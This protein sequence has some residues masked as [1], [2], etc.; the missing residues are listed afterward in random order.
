MTKVLST[1]LDSVKLAEAAK[2]VAA[3]G[4][5]AFRT[6]TFYGL[7]ADPFNAAAVQKMRELKGREE[8]KPILLLISDRDQVDRFISR[9]TTIFKAVADR[10]WPGPITLIGS[11]RPE[12]PIELTAGSQTIGLRLPNDETVR[13]LVRACGGS[14]TATSANPS[15]FGP[16]INAHE[17]ESYFGDTLD[18]IVDGGSSTTT[19]PS[20]V[21]DL[22]NEEPKLIR[23]GVIKKELLADLL[24]PHS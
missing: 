4:V 18:M 2:I 21:L 15:G 10:F 13:A 5:I 12:L 24:D 3:G 6:D 20:T 19:E 16:A 14:L 1:R 17:V 23:E 7:G 8:G 22:S 9:Q 11:A